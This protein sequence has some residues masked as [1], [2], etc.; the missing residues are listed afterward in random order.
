MNTHRKGKL[1]STNKYFTPMFNAV[2][3]TLDKMW[4]QTKYPSVD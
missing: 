1:L 2:L 3:F 4:M